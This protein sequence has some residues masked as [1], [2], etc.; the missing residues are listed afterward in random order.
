MAYAVSL[1]KMFYSCLKKLSV[2]N[3]KEHYVLTPNLKALFWSSDWL[4]MA[5]H[6]PM[7]TQIGNPL[8]LKV[9]PQ[10]DVS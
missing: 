10:I 7:R 9:D 5:L 2:V 8:M 1:H 3:Q 6:R 4:L